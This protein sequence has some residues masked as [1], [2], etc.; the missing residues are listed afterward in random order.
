LTQQQLA[1]GRYTKA[2]VSALERGHAKPSMAALTFLSSRLGVSPDYFL[3][4]RP[5]K[6]RRVDADILLASG[7]YQAA[8]DI[9]Q[10]IL[11]SRPEQGLRAETLCG[12]AEAFCR[13]GRGLEAVSAAAESVEIFRGLDRR[14]E[15]LLGTY[16]LAYAQH[17]TS[18]TGEARAL[19]TALLAEVR[20]DD[21]D[22]DLRLRVLMAMSAID[23]EEE[24]HQAALGY[25]EEA[26]ALATDLDDRRR[27]SFL[28]MLAYSYASGGDLE[29]AIRTGTE[30]LGLFRAAEAPREVAV[31][32]NN[33][34]LAYLRV[35]N[36]SRAREYAAR[37]RLRHVADDDRRLLAHVADTEAQIQLAGGNHLAASKL[38]DEAIDHAKASDNARAHVSALLTRA[39]SSIMADD[40]NGAIAAYGAAVEIIR[41]RGPRSRLHEPL[42][43][44]ADL[45][46]TL[47]RHAEAYALAR[48]A[49][50]AL[51]PSAS[52]PSDGLPARWLQEAFAEADPAL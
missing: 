7:R 43:R 24:K 46:A 35:G 20:R 4:D 33:L 11:A 18:N 2:Y 9:Y 25:L 5:S 42:S 52:E 12:A 26:R 15:A 44:W 49:L 51:E 13:L 41:K 17:L 28:S 47:G 39:R 8:A 29:G 27:A 21:G 48:E 40:G 6:W 23:A 50:S 31:L 34:A 32:E 19:L 38:A 10:E 14:R 45:L 16:W 30:S 1:Q 22:P 37:A 3:T 36:V